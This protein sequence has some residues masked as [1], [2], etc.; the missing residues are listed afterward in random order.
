MLSH[1]HECVITRT[2]AS[3]HTREWVMSRASASLYTGEGSIRLPRNPSNATSFNCLPPTPPSPTDVT[4]RSPGPHFAPSAWRST[5]ATPPTMPPDI[6]LPISPICPVLHSGFE[7]RASR[8]T[9]SREVFEFKE[10]DVVA[11]IVNRSSG[12]GALTPTPCALLGVSP[13]ATCGANLVLLTAACIEGKKND[14]TDKAL[15]SCTAEE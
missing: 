13:L 10:A 7:I 8:P 1:E 6:T 4:L 2:N 12:D 15:P 3:C 5:S 11:H 9:A 14:E